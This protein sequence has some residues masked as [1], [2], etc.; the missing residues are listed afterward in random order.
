EAFLAAIGPATK[1]VYLCSP[2]NPTG[3][4]L[5]LESLRRVADSFE[6][7]T[8]V[9]E[10]YIDFSA[11][12]SC[13]ELLPSHPNLVVLQTLSKA[14]AGAGIRLGMA[15]ASEAIISL[16]SKVKYPYNISL[17]SQ[18]KAFE[19]LSRT[20]EKAGEVRLLLNERG[21]MAT[22]LQGLSFVRKVYPSDANFL[23]V[24]VDDADGRYRGL[25]A[26]GIVVRNRNRVCLC[27]GCLRITVGSPKEND[28][29]LRALGS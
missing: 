12:P 6:G 17:P 4:A 7:I 2:N 15:F 27:E 16:L 19:I 26:Q 3:N 25:V 22:A 14:W 21:R 1:I 20:A 5:P 10:A 11:S 13:L 28:A 23:L 29:L 24:R 8:V 18:E 9:D